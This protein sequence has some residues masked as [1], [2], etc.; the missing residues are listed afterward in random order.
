MTGGTERLRILSDGKIGIGVEDPA[1]LLEIEGNVSSTTQFSG[2]DGLRVHNANGSAHGVTA[3]MYFT[4]GTGSQNRG[5]AI[6]VEYTSA[7]SGNDLYFAT[8]GGAVTSTN[9]LTERLRITSA[10][11]VLIGT[12]TEGEATADNLTIADSGHCGITLR[13]GTGS[14]GTMF[15]SDGTSSTAEYEGYIQYDHSANYLKFATNHTERLAIDSDGYIK[16]TGT[17]TGDETNK[18][19]RFL[20]PSHDTN[21]EDVMYFQM[22]QEASFNQLEIGGGSG[23]YNAATKIILKTAAIDTVAGTSRLE[24]DSSGNVGIGTASPGDYYCTDLVVNGGDDTGITIVCG[25]TES[26]FLCFADGTS[27]AARYSGYI[28]YDHNVDTLHLRANGGTKGIDIQSDGD[29]SITDGNLV[30]ANTHG[31]DFSAQTQSTS[32]TDDE[33]LDHYEKGQWTPVLKKNGVANATPTTVHGRYIRI[34]KLVWLSC[35]IYWSSG[36]NAQGAAGAWTLSGLPFSLQDDDP[37]TCRI[38]QFAPL[39]YFQ[40]DG[41]TYDYGHD[42]RWQINNSTYFQLYTD[43][44]DADRAW[45]TGVMQMAMTGTFMLHE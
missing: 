21:E 43:I 31:I 18:L 19:G 23:S 14:V 20:M 27:G 42:S 29:L 6:G 1:G 41:V 15:F 10:G 35:F 44:S 24:I 28:G 17:R 33:L 37:G 32:T 2:F 8:N 9:T 22:Q 30:V 38:Y 16:Y 36:S 45:T 11:R 4:A 7:A 5:A 34:G 3:D 39:G 40:I 13:S 26:S 25:A 12:T